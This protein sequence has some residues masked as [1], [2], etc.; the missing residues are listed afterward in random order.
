MTPH[1]VGGV[2]GITEGIN[3]FSRPP[4]SLIL[5]MFLREPGTRARPLS[6]FISARLRPRTWLYFT[7]PSITHRSLAREPERG[8][9]EAEAAAAAPA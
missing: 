3:P 7:P 8:G 2:A 6:A 1:R 5:L 9:R 4:I